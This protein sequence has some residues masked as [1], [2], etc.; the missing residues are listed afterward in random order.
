MN[1]FVYTTPARLSDRTQIKPKSHLGFLFSKMTYF[2]IVEDH[3]NSV[4]FE[5]DEVGGFNTLGMMMSYLLNNSIGDPL[6]SI[7]INFPDGIPTC[8]FKH[9]VPVL[10]ITEFYEVLETFIIKGERK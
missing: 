4:V 9:K 7:A 10:N 5:L 8:T 3:C 6:F 1:T 2:K